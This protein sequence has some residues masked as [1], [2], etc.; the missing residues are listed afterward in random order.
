MGRYYSGDISGK[1]WFAVQSSNAADRFGVDGQIPEHLEYTFWGDDLEAVEKELK[2]IEESMGK[3]LNLLQDYFNG[4]AMYSDK[5]L[6]K[7][8]K[9][10]INQLQFY[11]S[12]YADYQLGVQIRDCIK[13]NGTCSFKAEL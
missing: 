4:K 13:Q 10:E 5:E 7:H 3:Y 8:L 9:L 1:F 2:N 11:L 6:A 12:E